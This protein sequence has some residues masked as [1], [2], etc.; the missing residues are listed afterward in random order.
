MT[1]FSTPRARP[2]A[3]CSR[4]TESPNIP[5]KKACVHFFMRAHLHLSTSVMFWNAALCSTLWLGTDRSGRWRGCSPGGGV[6]GP[7]RKPPVPFT[8]IPKALLLRTTL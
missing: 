3:R 4:P 6:L 8:T 7:S 5:G 2:T 1:R